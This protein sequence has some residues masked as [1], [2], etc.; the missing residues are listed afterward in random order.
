[1][2]VKRKFKTFGILRAMCSTRSNLIPDIPGE[3]YVPGGL[4]GTLPYRPSGG[5]Y[6]GYQIGGC[7]ASRREENDN[8]VNRYK[9]AMTPLNCHVIERHG[10]NQTSTCFHPS[11]DTVAF[12]QDDIRHISEKTVARLS[13]EICS[14]GACL[15]SNSMRVT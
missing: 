11:Y 6:K 10:L 14:A 3:R 4:G 2:P 15:G 1:M 5:K 12:Q 8:L 7:N 9:R 13:A